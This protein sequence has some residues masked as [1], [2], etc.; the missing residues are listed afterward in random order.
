MSLKRTRTR[1]R[2][3][4]DE[5]YETGADF[6][7]RGGRGSTSEVDK[8]PSDRDE[9]EP[10]G[11]SRFA[12]QLDHADDV[13]SP[14]RAGRSLSQLPTSARASP[15]KK[16]RQRFDYGPSP[17]QQRQYRSRS[18]V[19]GVTSSRGRSKR[20]CDEGYEHETESSDSESERD[21]GHGETS[22]IA[23]DTAMEIAKERQ[24]RK[25]GLGISPC[26]ITPEKLELSELFDYY[27]R[28][29]AAGV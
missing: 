18:Y 19:V 10:Y 1:G 17:R 7:P 22:H 29:L 23:M 6:A 16:A 20:E 26:G 13:A 11:S 8:D 27:V 9:E 15:N 14:P 2:I 3:A 5:A 4:D 25:H 12:E 28:F 21:D 24:S